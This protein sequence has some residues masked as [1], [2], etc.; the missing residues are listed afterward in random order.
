MTTYLS[1]RF[2]GREKLGNLLNKRNLK[3]IG[4]EVGTHRGVY[5]DQFM[6]HWKGKTL[7]CVDP[8][9]IPEG[10]EIQSKCLKGKGVD[11]NLDFQFAQEVEVK[12]APRIKLIRKLS[13]DAA[14]DFS[15]NSLD[16][17]YLDGDH[18]QI[19]LDLNLWWFKVKSGGLIAGHD[20]IS[21]RHGV[22]GG[23]PPVADEHG[24][25]I[26]NALKEF[27]RGNHIDIYLIP[28]IMENWSFF[29]IKP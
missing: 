6:R 17:V 7:Y 10:Y 14:K 13:I 22:L 1:A 21:A 11:R 15:S 2:L 24:T 20:I 5:A 28:E 8:W 9:S 29:I 16:F 18:D 26:R 23:K 3:N 19:L 4:V 27:I 12:H 25:T